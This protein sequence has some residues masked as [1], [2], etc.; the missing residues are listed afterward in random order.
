MGWYGMVWN[1]M[2]G[3]RQARKKKK[4]GKHRVDRHREGME[5]S[6]RHANTSTTNIFSHSHNS[7]SSSSSS[8]NR[9]S[10]N[11]L[12]RPAN[13]QANEPLSSPPSSTTFTCTFRSVLFCSL[14]LCPLFSSPSRAPAYTLRRTYVLLVGGR[15]ARAHLLHFFIQPSEL[16]TEDLTIIADGFFSWG[17]GVLCCCVCS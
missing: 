12:D 3:I 16:S 1:R 4:D 11:G 6:R 8:P 5:V 2:V 13:E 9:K 10:K 17:F 15:L 7:S 14:L